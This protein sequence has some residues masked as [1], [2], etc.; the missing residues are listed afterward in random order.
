[1]KKYLMQIKLLDVKIKQKREEYESLKELTQ[2]VGGLDYSKERVQ[3][4][5]TSSDS[6]SNSVIRY[7][8]LEDEIKS[9]ICKLVE[10]RHNAIDMIHELTNEQYIEILYKRYI[11][12]KSLE[13]IAVEMNLSYDYVRHLHGQALNDL[14]QKS[15]VIET[16]HTKA[17]TGM[18]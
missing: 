5:F 4:G 11:E 10:L 12:Y 2:S 7:I 8:E 14:R 13:L 16:K 3:I 15:Q 6:L 17:Q 1:M 9:D 18:L